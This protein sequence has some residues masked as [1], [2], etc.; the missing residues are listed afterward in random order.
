MKMRTKKIIIIISL[1]GL[2]FTGCAKINITAGITTDDEAFM[3]YYIVVST[4]YYNEEVRAEIEEVLQEI[5]SYWQSLGYNSSLSYEK[6]EYILKY[7]V[8]KYHNNT[9]EALD[10]LIEYLTCDISIFSD[11][12]YD[13]AQ[14]YFKKE[15]YIKGSTDFSQIIAPNL[16]EK[17][18]ITAIQD[19]SYYTQGVTANLYIILP[20]REN[21]QD[22]RL[23]ITEFYKEI[24]LE[25]KTDF[26]INTVIKNRDSFLNYKN[27]DESRLE[28][29]RIKYYASWGIIALCSMLVVLVLL[30]AFRKIKSR[31]TRKITK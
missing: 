26:S 20:G 3:Q 22:K 17:Y 24:S 21:A 9:E 19:I 11:I 29:A 25:E 31:N 13:Y 5:N 12:E 23:D 30:L 10:T 8:S 28:Y 18:P 7:L 27:L 15:L 1:V 14:S 6:N 4:S 16:E 2:M